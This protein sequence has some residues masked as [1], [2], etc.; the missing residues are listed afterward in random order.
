MCGGK[1][2]TNRFQ[3]WAPWSHFII[4]LKFQKNQKNLYIYN[5]V[6]Y[7]LAKSQRKIAC[8]SAYT[9]ITNSDKSEGP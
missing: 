7:I 1:L 8:I 9:E 5:D 6:F 3:G 4:Y 2:P